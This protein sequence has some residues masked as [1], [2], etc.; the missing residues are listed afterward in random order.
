MRVFG[1]GEVLYDISFSKG[2]LMGGS[3]G[4]S[5]VNVL[6]TLVELGYSVYLTSEV[7][8]DSLGSLIEQYV[9]SMGIKSELFKKES[10]K[11]SLALAFLDA[12]GEAE[13]SFYKTYW[14]PSRE[15]TFGHKVKKNDI[16]LFGSLFSIHNNSHDWICRQLDKLN[17]SNVNI[18]YDP[19]LRKSHSQEFESGE[20]RLKVESCMKRSSLIKASVED[21]N[22]LWGE[23]SL[24][25]YYEKV[26]LF[27]PYLILTRADKGVVFYSPT[28]SKRVS[29]ISCNKLVSTVGAG[30]NLNA[31]IIS[32]F[33]DIGKGKFDEL[34][35]SEW[36]ITLERGV[37]FGSAVCG[38]K[39]SS[40]SRAELLKII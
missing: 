7:G 13:Y 38:V 39:E 1:I 27:C 25:E 40:L 2:M 31:G 26:R 28:F 19:N 8:N 11:T 36:L 23:L 5:V 6:S 18:I 22:I 16:V 9:E 37:K 33:I 14:S 21:L 4:G 10:K 35:Q 34:N 30:D 24:E 17:K 12:N 3:T 15:Q 32:S 29:S 20:L